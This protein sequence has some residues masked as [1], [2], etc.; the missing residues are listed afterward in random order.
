MSVCNA[1][2]FGQREFSMKIH[3]D[4]V[5][6]ALNINIGNVSIILM[7]HINVTHVH[8]VRCSPL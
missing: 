4:D 8:V 6:F 5:R 2:E 7:I 1:L 3:I